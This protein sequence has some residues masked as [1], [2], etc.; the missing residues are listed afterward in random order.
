MVLTRS[1]CLVALFAALSCSVRPDREPAVDPTGSGGAQGGSAGASGSS[2]GGSGGSSAGN[3]GSGDSG[4]NAGSAGSDDAGKAADSGGAPSYPPMPS[5]VY[6]DGRRLMVGKLLPD[7]GL[8]PAT[9]Y[10]LKGVSWSPT[11]IGEN[12]QGY[13]A[14]YTKYG[15]GDAELMSALHANSVKTYAPFE[16]TA[17][18]RAL[19]DNLYSRGV[20]VI[21]SVMTSAGGAQNK[22]YLEAVNSFKNHPGILMWLVG[23]EF[24]YNLLFGAGSFAR[25]VQ[26]VN[27]AIDD[28]HAADPDHPVAVSFGEI[29]TA[30]QYAQVP[31]ADVWS[32]NLYPYVNFGAR[33]ST[34]TGLSNKPMMIGE[35][36]ADAWDQRTNRENL[37]A[38]A[39][40][41]DQLTRQITAQYSADD[42]AR[43]VL[44]G[45]PFTLSDE[46][47]KAEGSDDT[48]DTGGFANAIYPDGFANEEWW[49]LCTIE[50]MPRPAFTTLSGIYSAIP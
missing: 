29:P 13:S 21:M 19:L 34:W 23:N 2:T 33:F 14:K 5:R 47:W 28:I 9:P 43:T 45:T 7:G 30:D 26:I 41:I 10:K 40:A 12:N 20:M 8:E 17:S 44:G 24:N 18:G 4:G 49:G 50:R 35:Y 3:G 11:G 27:T 31:N 39:E 6:V 32:I 22:R 16:T 15:P 46:W 48:H 1:G 25:A 37:P 38:Q 42:P 36:G